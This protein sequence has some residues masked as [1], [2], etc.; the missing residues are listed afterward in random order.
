ME[1]EMKE[2][3][4]A[5][6]QL[7]T[8]IC[9]GYPDLALD[10]RV[11]AVRKKLW[12]ALS[13][14]PS[15]A[16]A[17]D[18]PGNAGAPTQ[19]GG[20]TMWRTT[21]VVWSDF[22]PRHLEVSDLVR[23]GESGESFI[24]ESHSELVRDRTQWPE[25][26]FFGEDYMDERAAPLSGVERAALLE[27]AFEAGE[28]QRLAEA[29]CQAYLDGYWGHHPDFP[30]SDWRYEADNDTTR[31]GYWE[32]VA[33]QERPHRRTVYF[34]VHEPAGDAGSG[35]PLADGV[36]HVSWGLSEAEQVAAVRVG[37]LADEAMQGRGDAARFEV[38][39][40][41]DEDRKQA[42]AGDPAARNPPPS[43]RFFEIEEFGV[44]EGAVAKPSAPAVG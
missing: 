27:E 24:S 22:D 4:K 14:A 16:A 21:V 17:T 9:E 30:E 37:V 26:E 19:E 44:D 43:P 18:A 10:S 5:A 15:T 34:E 33:A 13:D 1:G 32:W 11:H 28:H 35:T 25:T 29:L 36:G 42:L 39:V 41:A 31:L 6:E 38:L 40:W 2:A 12:A 23:D 8:A 20:R 7:L 3:A